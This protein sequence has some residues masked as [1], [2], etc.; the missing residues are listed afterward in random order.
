MIEQ[1]LWELLSLKLFGEATDDELNELN[2]LIAHRPDLADKMETLKKI[3]ASREK[4]GVDKQ[5][6]FDRHLQR[7]SNHLAEPALLYENTIEHVQEIKPVKE[8]SWSKIAWWLGGAAA[9]AIATFVFIGLKKQYAKANESLAKNTVTTRPGSK[10]KMQLP[11]GTTVMLNAGSNISYNEIF[12]SNTREV[13]LSGEAYFDVTHDKERPFIIHTNSLDIRVLGTAFNVRSYPNEKTTETSLLRGSVEISIHDNPGKKIILK[14]N[15]KLVMNNEVQEEKI[16][17][18]VREKEEDRAIMT[19]SKI[20]FSRKDSSIA[21]TRW[22]QDRLV[23]DDVQL[24]TILQ[25]LE[26]S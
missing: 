16:N 11:D 22:M 25:E 12:N 14:P 19:L 5:S 8:K 9:A 17:Q 6:A 18:P 21:E 23:F 15:E 26:R 2:Q 13:H 24:G 4:G 3:W 7:L 10:T 1:R 20:H